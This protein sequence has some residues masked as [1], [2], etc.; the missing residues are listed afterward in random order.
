MANSATIGKRIK[1][2]RKKRGL[3]QAGL[4]L[5]VHVSGS[6]ISRIESGKVSLDSALL[7][8]IAEA[9]HTNVCYL[10]DFQCMTYS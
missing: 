1:E 2:V 7:V 6:T 3:T 5:R 9:L 8:N 10:L 4:G